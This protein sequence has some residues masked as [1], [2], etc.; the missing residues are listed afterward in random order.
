M[1]FSSFDAGGWF[2]FAGTR[3]GQARRSA[4]EFRDPGR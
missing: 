2:L 4:L 1:G 3:R